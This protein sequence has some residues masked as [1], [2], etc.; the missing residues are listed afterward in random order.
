M[1]YVRTWSPGSIGASPLSPAE[2]AVLAVLVL[3][4]LA[5]AWSF[6]RRWTG[7]SRSDVSGLHFTHRER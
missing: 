1:N 7:R 2:M 5:T 6:Y 4:V 3:L